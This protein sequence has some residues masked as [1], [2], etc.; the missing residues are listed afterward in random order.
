MHNNGLTSLM[1]LQIYKEEIKKIHIPKIANE[2]IAKLK[3]QENS[4]LVHC[5]FCNITIK[6]VLASE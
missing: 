1:L 6:T 2:F 3:A 4:D 5:K